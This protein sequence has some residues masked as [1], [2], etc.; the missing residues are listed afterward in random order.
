VKDVSIGVLRKEIN[1]VSNHLGYFQVTVD[2][3]DYLILEKTFYVSGLVK[4]SNNQ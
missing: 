3:S 1:T 4:I 2:T